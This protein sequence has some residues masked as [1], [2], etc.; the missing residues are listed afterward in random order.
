MLRG[1][2]GATTVEKN[3]ADDIKKAT[4]E[5]LGEILNKNSITLEDIACANF[6]MTKDLDSAYPAKFAREYASF[7]KVPMMCYQEL[8]IE[9]ALERCIRVLLL[10]NSDKKQESFKH[11]YLKNAK[12]LR[13]D[14]K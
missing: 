13:P 5:L 2:R 6:T 7:E 4:V 14:L 3:T 8:S 10:V 11:I 1:I 9:G 12:K